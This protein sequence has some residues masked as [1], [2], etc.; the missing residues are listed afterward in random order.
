MGSNW[1][2]RDEPSRTCL[3]AR[4]TVLPID[5]SSG[6][7]SLDDEIQSS[8]ERRSARRTFA[9]QAYNKPLTIFDADGVVPFPW[10]KID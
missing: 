5:T 8:S 4:H 1:P 10:S 7:C 3:V 2:S 6:S 9:V